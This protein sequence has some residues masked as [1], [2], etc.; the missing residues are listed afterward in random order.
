[1]EFGFLPAPPSLSHIVKAVW[2]ARGSRSEFDHAEP[3]VPD[4]CVELI[5]NLAD[6]FE[7]V[8]DT[9]TRHRQPRDLL[10]GP[11][12]QPTTAVPTGD[13]DLLGLRFWPGR[14]SAFL[15]APMWSLTDR[16][17]SMSSVL[18]GSDR[19]LDSLCEQRIEDRL[20]HLAAAF[21]ARA[22]AAA[23]DRSPSAVTRALDAIE[24]HRGTVAIKTIS[25]MTGVSRRHLERQFQDEVG[26]GAKH[27]ARIARVHHAL[28]VM[29]THASFSGADI[30]AHCGYTDQSHLIR[31]CREL[32][33]T[34]P[35]RM[36]TTE[37]TL[38]TLM[39]EDG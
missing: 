7:E 16:L 30:A 1:M 34:T 10:V 18:T 20:D 22:R 9:G 21:A 29:K 2:F 19:L 4:G 39:R 37:T 14:T 25:S 27:V 24:R 11:T 3:I 28:R 12:I 35:S 32:T 26:L 38:A 17:I 33:G 8:D 15:R 13:V 36:T 6:P 5:F 23:S 31:E